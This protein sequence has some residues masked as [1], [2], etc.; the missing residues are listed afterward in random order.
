MHRVTKVA[1]A[2]QYVD[3]PVHI[4]YDMDLDYSLVLDVDVCQ[5]S[6][7]VFKHRIQE[8]SEGGL[9]RSYTPPKINMEHNDGGFWKMIFLFK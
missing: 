4:A 8:P 1:V 6:L 3:S 7:L 2:L 5:H 9:I